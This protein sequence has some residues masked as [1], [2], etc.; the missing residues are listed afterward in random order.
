MAAGRTGRG[1]PEPL[2][3]VLRRALR[4][5]PRTRRALLERAER[6]WAAAAGPELA[7]RARVGEF[8][9]GILRVRVES[10]ALLQ[11]LVAFRRDELLARL[12]ENA[13]GLRIHELRFEMGEDL[14]DAS[15]AP[16]REG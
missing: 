3:Q 16:S 2:K 14:A 10:S 4:Q 12:R 11:E 8:R 13:E 7:G 1:E 15:P 6:A 5:A 9:R